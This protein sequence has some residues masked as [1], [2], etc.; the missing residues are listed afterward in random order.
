MDN[1]IPNSNTYKEIIVKGL[2]KY[3]PMSRKQIIDYC[4]SKIELTK[5]AYEQRVGATNKRTYVNRID[6]ALTLLK[7]NGEAKYIDKQY[8]LNQAQDNEPK[9]KEI[10]DVSTS[11]TINRNNGVM[12]SFDDIKKRLPTFLNG[13]NQDSLLEFIKQLFE[14]LDYEIQLTKTAPDV[15]EGYLARDEFELFKT[16]IKVVYLSE[17]QKHVKFEASDS[18]RGIKCFAI[19]PFEV[20]NI[21]SQITMLDIDLIVSQMCENQIMLK[22]KSIYEFQ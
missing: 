15:F 19:A 5:E 13:L 1:N 17:N 22:K 6:N 14:S 4:N 11:I 18:W 10:T 21:D 8:Y 20:S 12:Y 9:N 16:P 3:A 2:A 7:N